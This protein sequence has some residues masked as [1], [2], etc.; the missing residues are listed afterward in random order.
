MN[1]LLHSVHRIDGE[2]REGVVE[3]MEEEE[4]DAVEEDDGSGFGLFFWCH[5][6]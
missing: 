3:E 1:I 6:K 5:F 4:E 2:F